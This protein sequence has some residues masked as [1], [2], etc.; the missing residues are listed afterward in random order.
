M[1]SRKDSF[2]A[3]L[4]LFFNYSIQTF[5]LMGVILPLLIYIAEKATAGIGMP[6]VWACRAQTAGIRKHYATP[7]ITL[8]D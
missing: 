7:G 4:S 3:P 6:A 5:F 2:L 1:L 8:H